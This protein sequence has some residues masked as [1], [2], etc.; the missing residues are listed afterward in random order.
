MINGLVLGL[1]NIEKHNLQ[2]MLYLAE[3]KPWHTLNFPY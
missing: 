1:T 2:K 3:Y